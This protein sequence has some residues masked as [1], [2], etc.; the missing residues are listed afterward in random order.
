MLAVLA[1]LGAVSTVASAGPVAEADALVAIQPVTMTIAMSALLIAAISARSRV[2]FA[3]AVAVLAYLTAAF[4]RKLVTSGVADPFEAVAGIV[5]AFTL[6][7]LIVDW[8][9]YWATGWWPSRRSILAAIDWSLVCLYAI[10]TLLVVLLANWA[11]YYAT[12]GL[13]HA[14]HPS[15]A[16]VLL[17][18][19]AA[20][21]LA[22]GG[23]VIFLH[24]PAGAILLFAGLIATVV[25]VGGQIRLEGLPTQRCEVV[26]TVLALAGT[27][28]LARRDQSERWSI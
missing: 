14:D 17:A 3:A 19:T 11:V 10:L 2:G 12:F 6:I 22:I 25:A 27:F 24:R 21:A 20:G 15:Q 23:M 28:I 8:R 1:V 26:M 18:A 5:G 13:I 9:R 16:T 7:V 4:T